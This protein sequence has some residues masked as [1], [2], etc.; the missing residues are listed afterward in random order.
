MPQYSRTQMP[1]RTVRAWSLARASSWRG[2]ALAGYVLMMI[3]STT[4]F[5]A[6]DWRPE[7]LTGVFWVSIGLLDMVLAAAS[8]LVLRRLDPGPARRFWR[9][10]T[11]AGAAI[12]LGDVGRGVTANGSSEHAR[13]LMA[14]VQPVMMAVGVLAVVATML[15]YPMGPRTRRERVAFW[16]DTATVLVGAGVFVWFLGVNSRAVTNTDIALALAAAALL[17]VAAFAGI[18]VIFAERPPTLRA[19]RSSSSPPALSR[20]SPGP[21]CRYRTWTTASAP[22]LSWRSG[23]PRATWSPSACWSSSGG[24]P[25]VSRPRP[26]AG[27]AAAGTAR[28]RTPWWWGCSDCCCT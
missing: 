25:T 27:S 3:V 5:I 10:M 26:A 23:S 24:S 15:V 4:V 19:R 14:N 18:R 17:L 7:E 9:S 1:P 11:V 21:T 22:A 13:A 6:G 28:C 12:L 20:A 8:W 16:L 2:K